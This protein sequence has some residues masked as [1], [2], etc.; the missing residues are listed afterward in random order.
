MLFF[1]PPTTSSG[2]EYSCFILKIKKQKI[3]IYHFTCK[4]HQDHSCNRAVISFQSKLKKPTC[5]KL[6]GNHS[7][8]PEKE[9]KKIRLS[10]KLSFL[11][12]VLPSVLLCVRVENVLLICFARCCLYP[13]ITFT[14]KMRTSEKT[15]RWDGYE[16][17]VEVNR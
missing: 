10:F 17:F 11:L 12:P 4:P 6:N 16:V 2:L 15:N 9:Q 8:K 7:E 13:L 14:H 3:S 5:V 1:L